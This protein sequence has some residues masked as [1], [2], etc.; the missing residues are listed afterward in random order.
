MAD[1]SGPETEFDPQYYSTPATKYE[2]WVAATQLRVQML[3]IRNLADA[4]IINDRSDIIKYREQLSSKDD[5]F[6]AF[7]ASLLAPAKD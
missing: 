1:S 5:E 6:G 2:L 3:M 4:I 7:T